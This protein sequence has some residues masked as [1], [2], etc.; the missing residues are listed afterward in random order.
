M[1]VSDIRFNELISTRPEL[2][3]SKQLDF[4]VPTELKEYNVAV[5]SRL[6]RNKY[7]K[8]WVDCV[9]PDVLSENDVALFVGIFDDEGEAVDWTEAANQAIWNEDYCMYKLFYRY[10]YLCND[11]AEARRLFPKLT[12]RYEEQA[13]HRFI[14]G[15]NCDCR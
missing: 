11:E 5:F 12:K 2:K 15:S 4:K 14:T 13:V 6:I 9:S 8:F 10:E 7:P 3:V 1:K